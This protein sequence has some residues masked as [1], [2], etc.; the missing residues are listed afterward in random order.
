MYFPS[1]FC[2]LFLFLGWEP[3]APEGAID[4]DEDWDKFEDEGDFYSVNLL[5]KVVPQCT[6]Q[7]VATMNPTGPNGL[8]IL[9]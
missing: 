1:N 5:L 4:W 3:G 9:V 8:V 2:L 6:S 7:R